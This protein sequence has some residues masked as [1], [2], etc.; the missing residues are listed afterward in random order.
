MTE[1]MNPPPSDTPAG[2]GW[3]KDDVFVDRLPDEI[4]GHM[5]VLVVWRVD[6]R[7]FREVG[8]NPDDWTRLCL[9]C[10]RWNAV[11]KNTPSLWNQI[12][13]R[14]A[15]AAFE[16]FI[17]RSGACPISV[18]A[19]LEFP[20]SEKFHHHFL[21]QLHPIQRV[22]L[23]WLPEPETPSFFFR[24][25]STDS[26]RRA[27]ISLLSYQWYPS[28]VF[29]ELFLSHGVHESEDYS[30]LPLPNCPNLHRLNLR[31]ICLAASSSGPVVHFP[32]LTVLT[33]TDTLTKMSD[34]LRFLSLC[35]ALE[36][37]RLGRNSEVVQIYDLPAPGDEISLRELRTLHISAFNAPSL[38]DFFSRVRYPTSAD[39]T[40]IMRRE[41]R[42]SMMHTLPSVLY[43][44]ITSP[45]YLQISIDYIWRRVDHAIASIKSPRYS[46]EFKADDGSNLTVTFLGWG[47]DLEYHLSHI[48]RRLAQLDLSKTL[49]VSLSSPTIPSH[50]EIRSFLYSCPNLQTLEVST[51][52]GDKVLES[53]RYSSDSSGNVHW[54]RKKIL[55][56]DTGTYS[57]VQIETSPVVP[58]LQSLD[59]TDSAFSPDTMKDLLMSRLELGDEVHSLSVNV[60][61]Y[62]GC[63]DSFQ[64]AIDNMFSISPV[65]DE[66]GTTDSLAESSVSDQAQRHDD[67]PKV[68]CECA[69]CM[70]KT[71]EE[72]YNLRCSANA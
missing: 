26:T 30:V 29:S 66:S 42:E 41:D 56:T 3:E 61:Y 50:G 17:K 39:V 71:Q 8:R 46:L 65:G 38:Q 32:K 52:E 70:G 24:T 36:T 28:P 69:S 33:M 45:T 21:V 64:E 44:R 57:S 40:V 11:A 14:W 1:D 43:S 35:P 47:T 53:L 58:N 7:E 20:Y 6:F 18:F 9:V 25:D 27:L 4:L 16:T 63:L 5:M 13:F 72:W 12:S 49:S 62:P 68:T 54:P 2:R 10:S 67:R 34:I 55:P 60:S 59:M 15:P 23:S 48:L 31:G 19:V 22:C 37:C 51:Q